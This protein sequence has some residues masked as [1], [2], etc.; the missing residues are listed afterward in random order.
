MASE[1]TLKYEVLRKSIA[2][3]AQSFDKEESNVNGSSVFMLS[4]ARKKDV[5]SSSNSYVTQFKVPTVS[6]SVHVRAEVFPREAC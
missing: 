4:R 1:A 2:A 3:D 6:R 5:W